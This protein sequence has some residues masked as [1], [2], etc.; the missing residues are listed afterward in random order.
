MPPNDHP[1]LRA[2]G[3]APSF[4]SRPCPALGTI[5]I[6]S[7]RLDPDATQPI[8]AMQEREGCLF[9]EAAITLGFLTSADIEV[10]LAKQFDYDLLDCNSTLHPDI[11]AAYRP[12]APHVEALRRLRATLSA[13]VFEPNL[14]LPTLAISSAESGEGKSVLAANLGVLYAQLGKRTLIID[15]NFRNPSQHRLFGLHNRLGLSNILAARSSLDAL[16]MVGGVNGLHVLSAGIIPPNPHELLARPLFQIVLNDLG[17]QFDVILIDT[18]G[19]ANFADV[20]LIARHA[21]RALVLARES[22]SRAN[23]IRA[24]IMDL[25]KVDVQVVGTVLH[26]F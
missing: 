7:G 9:G 2:Q 21:K 18:P 11:A 26:R 6:E 17:R 10:A 15:A 24:L 23:S 13:Q 8:L 20:Q 19:H 12:R 5:L 3:G 25:L 14:L 22:W 4:V 1:S 16:Q